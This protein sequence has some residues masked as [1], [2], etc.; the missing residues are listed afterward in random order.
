MHNHLEPFIE[1]IDKDDYEVVKG[2]N[3]KFKTKKNMKLIYYLYRKSGHNPISKSS[4]I[5]ILNSR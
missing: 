2:L 1:S 5:D 4:T 3:K